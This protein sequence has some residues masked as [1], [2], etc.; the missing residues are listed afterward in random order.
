MT[1][2]NRTSR[3]A[4]VAARRRPS[5]FSELFSAVLDTLD[6]EDAITLPAETSWTPAV[7]YCTVTL[8]R[9]NPDLILRS[10]SAT[11]TLY[12]E[13]RTKITD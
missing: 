8:A 7:T 10:V 6:T 13:R 12:V 2:Y 11:R 9:R 5:P 4:A 1:I 3:H